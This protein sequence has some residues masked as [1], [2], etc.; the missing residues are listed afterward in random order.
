MISRPLRS[1]GELSSVASSDAN[2]TF[3]T[4]PRDLTPASA[5]VGFK[6][7]HVDAILENAGDVG[8]LEV[9]A[10]N[11]MGDGGHPHRILERVRQDFPISLHGV[12]MS[13][14]GPKPISEDHLSRFKALVDRYQPA[15]VSEHLAWSTHDDIFM[16]D[17]LPLPY[18]E[19][20]LEHVCNHVSH[21]QDVIG[22]QIFLE[23][24]A[25]YVLFG[26]STITETDFMRSI[27]KRTGCGLL[28]DINNVFVSATNHK[29][30]A[31]E[32]LDAFPTDHVG[33]IH[34]A[35]HTVQKDDEGAPLLIDSHDRPVSDP[36]WELYEDV[37]E[38]AGPIPTLVEWDSDLPEWPVLRSEAGNAAK[39]LK[40]AQKMHNLGLLGERHAVSG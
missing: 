35:G 14:G 19:Q 7:D 2:S 15:M 18:T 13:I 37:V 27:V 11:Y 9:H 8:F 26:D 3:A 22:R 29:F 31:L 1:H 28:L 30:S 39:I 12:C 17:L 23:N 21:M 5:G 34:L 4:R 6:H 10:E 20:T 25:T 38:Q 33:E 36:V 32:Y 40:R 16:N 24:P